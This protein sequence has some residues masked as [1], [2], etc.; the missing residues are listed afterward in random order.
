MCVFFS[1]RKS[2]GCIEYFFMRTSDINLL[3]AMSTANTKSFI[4]EQLLCMALTMLERTVV[5]NGI[6][7]MEFV[8]KVNT[9]LVT[10]S[11]KDI[12]NLWLF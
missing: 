3:F 5:G 12:F 7:R 2:A 11:E 10:F 4:F 6:T 1:Y 9:L 8:R